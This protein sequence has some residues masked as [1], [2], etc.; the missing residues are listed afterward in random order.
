MNKAKKLAVVGNPVGHSFSP[1]MHNFIS[2]K[3]GL[4]YS[5][6]R[7][8]V[9]ECD[10]TELMKS[11][12]KENYAGVNVTIPYKFN[13]YKLSDVVSEKA[14]KF[15]SVNTCIFKNG[16]IYGYSTDADGLYKSLLSYN[17]DISGKDILFIGAGG[18]TKPAVVYFSELSAKSISIHNRT[19]EKAVEIAEYVKNLNNFDVEIGI[20]KNHYDLVINT[21][22]VGMSPDID[23]LPISDLSFIDADTFVYDMIY[24]PEKTLFLKKAEENGAK[25]ANGLGMLIYQGIISYELF[26]GIELPKTI[27]K[28][29]LTDVFGK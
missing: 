20:N 18:A 2:E 23:K 11:L 24:N 19:R 26:T 25:T 8:C 5:Y 9:E 1:M 17:F 3:M 4:D 16:K 12:E 27:Y 7:I 10:F 14:K 22:S 13:A 28:D 21:T 29:I 6:G 15:G